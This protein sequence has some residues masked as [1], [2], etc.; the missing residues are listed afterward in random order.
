MTDDPAKMIGP[1]TRANALG[2]EICLAL[3]L[4]LAYTAIPDWLV[5]WAWQFISLPPQGWRFADI[6]YW[7][8]WA[9]RLLELALGLLLALSAPI[10]S[11]ICLGHIRRHWGKVLLVCAL[12]A[13]VV[14]AVYP[15]LPFRP[16]AKQLMTVWLISP[17]AQDLMF[18]GYLYGRIESAAPSPVHRRIPI[19][20]AL[21]LTAAFFSLHHIVSLGIWPAGFVAFQMLYTFLGLL[22]VGLSRQWTGSFLYVVAA[23]MAVNFLAWAIP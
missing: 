12:P 15:F 16:F 3:V 22:L 6:D 14:L 18:I 10:R 1:R 5:Q 8:N 23:H 9:A 7:M 4:T 19:R 21:V 13:A 20:W 17:L 11:G 2:Q